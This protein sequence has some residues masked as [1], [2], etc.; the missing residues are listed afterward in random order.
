MIAPEKHPSVRN[1]KYRLVAKPASSSVMPRRS[2][3]ILGAVVLVPT[4]IPTWHMIPRKQ[5]KING[6]PK[7]FR[8]LTKPEALSGFSSSIGV[9]PNQRTAITAITMYTGNSTRHPNP[10]VGI[11]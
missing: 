2:I 4:S 11:A 8:Q 9:A 7:S 3:K 1:I 6:L 10:N 5:S